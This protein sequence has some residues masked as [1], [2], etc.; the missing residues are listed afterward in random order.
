[1]KRWLPILS[2]AAALAAV[3]PLPA[4]EPPK[5]ERQFLDGLRGRGLSKIALDYLQSNPRLDPEVKRTLPLELAK[6]YMS[7]AQDSPLAQRP[8]WYDLARAEL[9]KFAVGN[10]GKPEEVQALIQAARIVALQGKAQL[11]KAVRQ[12]SPAARRAEAVRARGIFQQAEKELTDAGKALD[13]LLTKY[14][15]DTDE[16][17]KVRENLLADKLQADFD[18]G[19]NTLFQAQSYLLSPDENDT[20]KAG[21]FAEKARTALSDLGR[22]DKN[23]PLCY[24]ARAWLIPCSLT[25]TEGGKA[26]QYYEALNGKKGAVPLANHTRDAKML[27]DYFHLFLIRFDPKLSKNV[28]KQTRDEGLAWLKRRDLPFFGNR[29]EG[30]GVAIRL[31]GGKLCFVP[32]TAAE[33]KDAVRYQVA[34]A[35][36]GQTAAYK[37]KQ[38]PGARKL[39]QQAAKLLAPL[40]KVESDLTQKARDL[41]LD[42]ELALRGGKL[43]WDRLKTFQDYSFKA[44]H[45]LRLY[46]DPKTKERERDAHL[47]NAARALRLALDMAGTARGALSAGAELTEAYFTLGDY[48]RA[49]LLGEYLARTYPPSE[50]TARAAAFALQAYVEILDVDK[51]LFTK[52]DDQLLTDTVLGR[53]QAADR[54]RFRA[55]AHFVMDQPDWRPQPVSQ[56]A[57]YHLGVLAF[58]ENNVPEAV[59]L[60][61]SLQ[62]GWDGYHIAQC[63]VVFWSLSLTGPDA[64]RSAT[65][66]LLGFDVRW[67]VPVSRKEKKKY[68]K[69]A[70][71]ALQRLP[72]LTPQSSPLTVQFHFA[73]RIDHCGILYR[74]KKYKELADFAAQLLK[75]YDGL[76]ATVKNLPEQ[77][78]TDLRLG[79]QTWAGYAQVGLA[80]EDYAAGK[81]DEVLKRTAPTVARVKKAIADKAAGAL[82]DD[83]LVVRDLLELTLRAHVQKNDRA[84]AREVL[85]FLQA[86]AGDTKLTGG[87]TGIKPTEILV[88]LVVQLRGQVEDLRRQGPAAEKQLAQTVANFTAFLNELTKDL[89]RLTQDLDKMAQEEDK[90]SLKSKILVLLAKSY[91]SLDKHKDA[92]ELLARVPRPKA[93]K[94]KGQSAEE[95]EYLEAQLLYARELRLDRQFRQAASVLKRTGLKLTGKLSLSQFLMAMDAEKEKVLLVEDQ[96]KYGKAI[97]QWTKLMNNQRFKRLRGD[98]D[99]REVLAGYKDENVRKRMAEPL[100]KMH[101]ELVKLFFDCHYHMVFCKFKFGETNSKEALRKKWVKK[102]ASH[103]LLLKRARSREGWNYTKDK[104]AAL[105]KKEPLLQKQVDELDRETK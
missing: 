35:Y 41:H 64:T 79:L 65:E 62:R 84:G 11:S 49:A 12:T 1:M 86:V 60:L 10:K 103:L 95:R 52:V 47:R 27:A 57:R 99:F 90:K 68:Q 21:T 36:V 85:G 83:F 39:F 50:E 102:A 3:S 59:R 32:A 15:A 14:K 92:A 7:L 13:A 40:E 67:P 88:R 30:Y 91:A 22:R 23:N 100:R 66:R 6:T 29:P 61:E 20:L 8:G 77:V 70:W 74:Q 42:I 89:D 82:K 45:E 73:A 2:L 76:A 37:N 44:R 81:N 105:L 56:Y 16:G 101:R 43:S 4:Q 71:E 19:L 97:T 38:S 34:E 48:H 46:Y 24:K 98:K 75:E 93:G 63:Q 94:K 72:A 78:Q 80:E 54:Q 58:K 33:V 31:G 26:L 104:F 18:L 87:P 17:R 53:T 55:F 96:R 25:M 69:H 51:D 5:L 9:Q 28:L